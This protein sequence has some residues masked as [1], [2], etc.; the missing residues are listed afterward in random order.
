MGRRAKLAR[1]LLPTQELPRVP[2]EINFPETWEVLSVKEVTLH[3]WER[4]GYGPTLFS[5]GTPGVH[6]SH[7]R[8]GGTKLLSPSGLFGISH[9]SFDSD[10]M[11]LFI[12]SW[13]VETGRCPQEPLQ[14]HGSNS[15]CGSRLHLRPMVAIRVTHRPQ[16]RPSQTLVASLRSR[17]LSLPSDNIP[18]MADGNKS[19]LPVWIL[20]LSP[21]CQ[22]LDVWCTV[23]LFPL[24]SG[25]WGCSLLFV[26]L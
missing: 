26:G 13:T 21:F 2:H 6:E 18:T 9:H 15:Q 22:P 3:A 19:F 7:T 11:G 1:A 10:L 20:H 23:L 25:G 5:I 17:L 24:K 4:N 16:A 12:Y 8:A 14:R